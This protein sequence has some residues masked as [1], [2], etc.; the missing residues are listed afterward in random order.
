MR[1][2][3]PNRLES[4]HAVGS[5]N[6]AGGGMSAMSPS[7]AP[8]STHFTMVSICSWLSERSFLN[9]WIPTAR[10]MCH[11]GISSDTTRSLIARAHGRTS[12]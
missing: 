12:G 1:S 9:F 10:S 2:G 11:G 7:G 6:W 3:S 5:G 4:R 8:P